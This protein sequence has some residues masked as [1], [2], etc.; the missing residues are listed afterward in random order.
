[1]KMALIP[2]PADSSSLSSLSFLPKNLKSEDKDEESEGS[3][4]NITGIT[5]DEN[6]IVTVT[7]KGSSIIAQFISQ[8]RKSTRLNSSHV[9]ISYAVFCLQNKIL[10]TSLRS[11]R[12]IINLP[13]P[14][15]V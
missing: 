13:H 9:A 10:P 3:G 1:M 7:D 12:T 15:L 4:I 2:L 11:L 8:D 14:P 6:G 5:V